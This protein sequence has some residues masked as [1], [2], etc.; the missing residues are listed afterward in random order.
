MTDLKQVEELIKKY[1]ENVDKEIEKVIPANGIPYISE[2][3]WHH[4]GT[5]GKRIRPA[6]CLM[7]CE[8]LGGN[9]EK[10]M[11]YAVAVEILHNMFL[12]HDDVEDEDTVR[13]D[14]PTVWVKYGIANAVNVGDY[15]IA[16]GYESI[17][18]SP[19]EKETKL[20]LVDIFTTVLEKTAIGQAYDINLR[21]DKEFSLEKYMKLIEHKTAYYLVFALVGGAVVAG[22]SDK[23]VQKIWELGKNM[24]PAFQIRDDIIDLTAGKGR[25]GFVGNDIRESKPSILYFYALEAASKEEKEKLVEIFKKKRKE[26]TEEEVKWVIE[27]YNKYKVIEK[28]QDYAENL[29]KEAFKVIEEIPIQNKQVFKDIATYIAERSK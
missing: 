5:G 9:P 16:A 18:K 21:A 6:L 7:T 8:A 23:V 13:R 2:P 29:T 25:G 20:R 26:K 3:V 17:M 22:S 14:Q 19:L 10:A 12:L 11:N 1:A 28:A 27:L 24:G 15:M 4:M